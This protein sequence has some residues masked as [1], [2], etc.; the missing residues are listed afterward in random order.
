MQINNKNGHFVIC[1]LTFH[2]VVKKVICSFNNDSILIYVFILV[3]II[4]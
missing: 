1:S 4:K 2:E 3:K